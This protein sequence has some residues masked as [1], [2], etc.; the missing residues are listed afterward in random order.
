MNKQTPAPRRRLFYKRCAKSEVASIAR[1]SW[2][3][4]IPSLGCGYR[5]KREPSYFH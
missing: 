4:N 3:Y 1:Q 5:A 2:C